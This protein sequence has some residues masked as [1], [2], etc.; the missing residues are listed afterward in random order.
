MPPAEPRSALE[1]TTATTDNRPPQA[2]IQSQGDT[3][4]HKRRM[5]TPVIS[6]FG[7]ICAETPFAWDSGS[8]SGEE[9]VI[10]NG[11]RI[12]AKHLREA[13]RKTDWSG[14]GALNAH[15]IA[16]RI[17]QKE[18][19]LTED[20]KTQMCSEWGVKRA[21]LWKEFKGRSLASMP[22]LPEQVW[23]ALVVFL[24]EKGHSRQASEMLSVMTRLYNERMKHTDREGRAAMDGILEALA[25]GLDPR[26][27]FE[28]FRTM[29]R[30]T[31]KGFKTAGATQSGSGTVY[32]REWNKSGHCRFGQNC[33][34]TH[35]CFLCG[36]PHKVTQCRIVTRGRNANR[37]N[38]NGGGANGLR[39]NN[40]RGT[41]GRKEDDKKR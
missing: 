12:S 11:K 13:R 18:T 35:R 34:F 15:R 25:S 41:Q 22:W 33:K 40:T 3:A 20:F 28:R 29:F 4:G 7:Q 23:I 5:A 27:A 38:T 9:D 8:D 36:R 14:H 2:A 17:M 10:I 6:K 39:D 37:G 1:L 32:C 19:F 30:T 16:R 21:Q 26:E 24:L 31:R